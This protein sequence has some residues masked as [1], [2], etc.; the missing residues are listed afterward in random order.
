MSG[1]Q[2]IGG[3]RRA[4]VF[5]GA[6]L[7]LFLAALDQLVIASA[8]ATIAGE[9]GHLGQSPWLFTS[10]LLGSTCSMLLWGRLGDL[11]GRRSVFQWA[12]ALFVA[13][14]VVAGLS[15]SMSQLVIGRT[16]QGLAAG[17]LYTLPHAIAADLVPARRRG[18]TLALFSGTWAISA[19]IGPW[20]SGWLV[21]GPGWRWIFYVNLPTGLLAIALISA[22]RLPQQRV[23]H[24]LDLAG[25]GLLAAG[26]AALLLAVSL[27]GEA[28]PWLSTPGV[29]LVAAALALL[30]LFVLQER[31]AAEPVLPVY[32]LR[33]PLVRGT[34]LANL[35]FGLAN[36]AVAVFVPLFAVVVQGAGATRAGLMLAP[37]P[38]GLF[39]TNLL[40]GQRIAATG[41]Y[42]WYPV[43]GL[44]VYSASLVGLGWMPADTPAWLFMTYS[45][46]AGLGSGAVTP[47]VVIALQNAVDHRHVGAATATAA[48]SRQIGQSVGTAALGALMV[49]RLGLHLAELVPAGAS[50][51]L[52]PADLRDGP[53]ALAALPDALRVRVGEAFR[54][55]IRDAYAVMIGLSL[56]S[57]L[58][59]ARLAE[60]RLGEAVGEAGAAAPTGGTRSAVRA[61]T[62]PPRRPGS[63]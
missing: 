9:L 17:A 57:T 30:P 41:R 34:A 24:R 49:A 44:L 38:L 18:R 48:F 47:V 19:L 52:D 29:L 55:A 12:V 62:A 8:M 46:V 4:L 20:I 50:G 31:R 3:A 35:V 15:S 58:L 21:E 37:L 39:L 22:L 61:S 1:A 54:R 11:Y 42:R 63:A 45:L 26:V 16:L 53:D 28:W 23:E 51:G 6:A 43:G 56:L 2:A 14:S 10:Y 7:G 40:V 25:A 33:H 59:F 60:M 36:F 5:A 27:G 13:A 32:M